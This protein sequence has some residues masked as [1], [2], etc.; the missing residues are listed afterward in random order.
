VR[1]IALHR[2]KFS[3]LGD[4]VTDHDISW[5]FSSL[6]GSTSSVLDLEYTSLLLVQAAE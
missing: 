4:M 5:K 3:I 1:G 6:R 2:S